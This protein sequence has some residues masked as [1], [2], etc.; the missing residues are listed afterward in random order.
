MVNEGNGKGD[1]PRLVLVSDEE[2]IIRWK[3]AM[4]ELPGVS[5]EGL[6]KRIEEIRSRTGKP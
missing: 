3:Y 6:N 4:G 2:H 1:T 5:E